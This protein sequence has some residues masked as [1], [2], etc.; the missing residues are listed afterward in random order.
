MAIGSKTDVSDNIRNQTKYHSESDRDKN[1]KL[2]L[3]KAKGK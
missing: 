3:G 2:A 1:T